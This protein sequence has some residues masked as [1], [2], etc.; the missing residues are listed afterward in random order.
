MYQDAALIVA[1]SVSG[2]AVT[3]Q[4]LYGSSTSVLSS[5]SIDLSTKRDMGEGEDLLMRV[6]NIAAYTGGTSVEFQAIIADDAA[7]TTNVTVIGT[8]GAIAVASLTAG[9][10][11]VAD[12]TPQ[13]GSLGRRYLGARA[14]NVGAN[15]T[16]TS[17][18][19]FTI[20][21]EDGGKFYPV[22]FSVS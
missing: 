22:G 5:Y 19:D 7:L 3:P 12:L 17:L 6:T 15:T 14:V 8:T 1:G 2:N 16:G 21:V 18:I 20:D 4:A 10:R 13:I 9:S 11:L